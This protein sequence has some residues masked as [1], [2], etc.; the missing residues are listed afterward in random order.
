MY[1]LYNKFSSSPKVKFGAF[2]LLLIALSLFMVYCFLPEDKMYLGADIFFHYRRLS[3]L[4]DALR[5]GTPFTYLDY[6]AA[7][8]F[9]Y[10][11]KWFYPDIFLLPFAW[12]GNYTSVH[13]AYKLIIFVFTVLSGLIAYLSAYQVFKRNV[14]LSVIFALL[15]SFSYYHLHNFFFRSALGEAVAMTFIPLVFLGL[16]HLIKGD[17]QKWFWLPIGL[18]LIFFSHLI[19]TVLTTIIILLIVTI[20][21]KDFLE[22]RRKIGL[23]I[24]SGIVT[25]LLSSVYIFPMFEQMLSGDFFYKTNPYLTKAQDHLYPIMAVVSGF[26]QGFSLLQT[27]AHSSSIGITLIMFLTLR[28]FVKTVDKDSQTKLVDVL[29][30]LGFLLIF[31]T[32]NLFPWRYSPLRLINFVQFP[33]RFYAIVSVFLATGSAYYVY[34]LLKNNRL[35]KYIFT[36]GLTF[37]IGW[38]LIITGK[39][40]R[41]ET[42]LKSSGV[43]TSNS[44]LSNFYHLG[45]LE[46]V[47][48]PFSYLDIDARKDWVASNNNSTITNLELKEGRTSLD[49]SLVEKSDQIELP[50]FYYKGYKAL[51]NGKE[52]GVIR[53]ENGLVSL[54][55]EESGR[56]ELFYGGTPIQKASLCLSLISFAGFI[57]YIVR[58]N[59]RKSDQIPSKS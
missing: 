25:C 38:M 34:L 23:L 8:E 9:G 51:L 13:F 56:V 14:F 22:D 50:R 29:V 33:T 52:I 10:A 5:Y 49:I 36:L 43:Y 19:S 16:F 59:K 32:S 20:S 58:F 1:D 26:F 44:S 21:Y 55:I 12:I 7:E 6:A 4:M 18:T 41:E 57:F 46:Y 47:P 31:I 40:F 48:A 35:R 2:L 15:Y 53:S 54:D 24:F 30:I 39:V 37:V 28:L 3:S 45:G 17:K 27:I 42:F 11:S